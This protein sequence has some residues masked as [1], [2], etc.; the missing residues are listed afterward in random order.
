M[1]GPTSEDQDRS[2]KKE[3]LIMILNPQDYIPVEVALRTTR[4]QQAY[5]AQPRRTVRRARRWPLL[6]RSAQ[7]RA[8]AA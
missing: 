7:R 5:R 8:A 3:V 6:T 2:T 4:A 1:W